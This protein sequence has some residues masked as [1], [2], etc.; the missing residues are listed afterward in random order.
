MLRKKNARL[1]S[2]EAGTRTP[3]SVGV[4]ERI[5]AREARKVGRTIEIAVA[6]RPA[7]M[8]DVLARLLDTVPGLGGGGSAG[9]PGPGPGRPPDPARVGDRRRR[10]TGPSQQG[11]RHAAEHQREDREEPPEQR[12]FQVEDRRPD[13]PHGL[14][15]SRNPTKDLGPFLI[16]IPSL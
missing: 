12:F 3:P 7:L 11:D 2:S 1:S 6:S 10:R 8:R 14:G 5:S 4:P 16:P 13:R 9:G 15:A